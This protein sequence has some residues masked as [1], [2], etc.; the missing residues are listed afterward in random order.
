MIKINK[1][2]LAVTL[3]LGTAPLFAAGFVCG[4]HMRFGTPSEADQK[5]CRDG[6]AAGYNYDHKVSE[7]VS[8]RMTAESAQGKIKRKDAFAEDKEVPVAYR[9]TLSDYKGSGYDRGHQAPAAD[10]AA[11]DITMKQSFLLTNM[12]PQL[13]AL[14]QKAWRILEEKARQW[15]ISRKDVQV[16]TGPIFTGSEESIGQGVTIPSAYYKIVMDPAKLQAIAFIM[17]QQDIP[18]S[19]IADYRVSVREVEE[20]THLNFFSDMPEEQQE[21]LEAR[22]S[23]MWN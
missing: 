21:T 11:T 7:W 14:N 4:E 22:V 9:A 15:A 8:Y 5:L 12:T 2:V 13:P 6:Y 23:P 10:M 1:L 18:V 20:Q 3:S 19:K 17:P 16:I